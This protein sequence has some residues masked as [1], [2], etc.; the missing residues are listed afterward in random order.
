MM[1]KSLIYSKTPK[2]DL[3]ELEFLSLGDTNLENSVGDNSQ[4]SLSPDP[5]SMQKSPFIFKK[6]FLLLYSKIILGDNKV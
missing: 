4:T 3:A 6:S 2:T 5:H 1:F